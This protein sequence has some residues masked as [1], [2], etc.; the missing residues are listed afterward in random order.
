MLNRLYNQKKSTLNRL[1]NKKVHVDDG[2][3][4]HVVLS[5]K[6]III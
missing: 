4:Y 3:N 2:L 5:Q 1:Y 6:K